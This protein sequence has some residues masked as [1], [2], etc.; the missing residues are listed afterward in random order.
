MGKLGAYYKTHI[1][2][3]SARLEF[4]I[5]PPIG[6]PLDIEFIRGGTYR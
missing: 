4:R 1:K 5:R 6:T 3:L 2:I